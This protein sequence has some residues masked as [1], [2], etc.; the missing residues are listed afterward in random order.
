MNIPDDTLLECVQSQA[1]LERQV[2]DRV[3]NGHFVISC[4]TTAFV[5][6]DPGVAIE[7]FFKIGCGLIGN[8]LGIPFDE[9][10]PCA[11]VSVKNTI[12]GLSALGMVMVGTEIQDDPDIV[13]ILSGL[14]VEQF[15]QHNASARPKS[16]SLQ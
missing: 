6:D 13:A 7:C 14:T 11:I 5:Y 8:L 15:E 16:M 1:D 4:G 3:A 10:V 2:A 9:E 12:T